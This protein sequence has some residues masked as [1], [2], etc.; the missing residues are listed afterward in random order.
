[1]VDAC[2]PG[3][4]EIY[5]SQ[6][7]SSYKLKGTLIRSPKQGQEFELQLSQADKHEAVLYGHCPSKDYPF[8]GKKAHSLVHLRQHAHLRART[9]LMSAIM[10]VRNS[11]SF[12]TH[13]FFQG[14]GFYYIHSPI[15]TCSDCE[16][17]GEMFQVTTMLP[18]VGKPLGETKGIIDP[19]AA[20]EK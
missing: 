17:A 4:D 6:L 7:G 13:Q 9:R 18:E 16:G 20:L 15:I 11:L 19:Y 12:A 2:I 8:A 1:M 3:F 10:R 14:Q 5:K